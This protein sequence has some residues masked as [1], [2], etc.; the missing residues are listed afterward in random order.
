M[1]KIDSNPIVTK[2]YLETKIWYNISK[3]LIVIFLAVTNFLQ[4]NKHIH[5]F[6]VDINAFLYLR[7]YILLIKSHAFDIVLGWVSFSF[8]EFI[9]SGDTIASDMELAHDGFCKELVKH[10]FILDFSC[11]KDTSFFE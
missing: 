10:G 4:I 2:I 8:G 3:L 6:F 1:M 11:C 7:F 9:L 5:F